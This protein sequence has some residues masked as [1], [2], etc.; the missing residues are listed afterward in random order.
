MCFRKCRQI[1]WRR[2][3]TKKH[4][5]K[6]NEQSET[7][8]IFLLMRVWLFSVHCLCVDSNRL[9]WW[10]KEQCLHVNS[11]HAI[12]MVFFRSF[13]KF[14]N[15]IPSFP[16]IFYRMIEKKVFTSIPVRIDRIL[17]WYTRV[18]KMSYTHKPILVWFQLEAD[19]YTHTQAEARK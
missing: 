10:K 5:C 3:L 11:W 4:S 7:I 6:Q 9:A 1:W 13:F 16:G 8:D 12:W 19:A 15:V 18:H 17:D 2:M 14:L